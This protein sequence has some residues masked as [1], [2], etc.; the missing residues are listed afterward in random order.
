[1]HMHKV[2][3]ATRELVAVVELS[4]HNIEGLHRLLSIQMQA[5]AAGAMKTAQALSEAATGSQRAKAQLAIGRLFVTAQKPKDAKTPFAAAVTVLGLDPPDAA[6]GLRAILLKE[7]AAPEAW[8]LYTRALAAYVADTQPG[9]QQSLAYLELGRSLIDRQR[10]V[11]EGIA[12]LS[13]GFSKNPASDELQLELALRLKAA[14][15]HADALPQIAALI[16]TA[17]HDLSRWSSMV[18][19]YSA[20]GKNA[21]VNLATGAL[22]HLGG[23]SE[24]QRSTWASRRAQAAM[25]PEGAFDAE[26]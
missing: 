7:A 16:Q 15:R 3:E 24:L 6:E 18:E 2:S 5:G 26:A 12:A 13:S 8:A 4:P 19:V 17:P 22:V 23:G 9:E 1:E 21:E 10:A 25:L 14:G 20:L 11:D